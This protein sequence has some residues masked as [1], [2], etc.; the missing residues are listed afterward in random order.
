MNHS[1]RN[2]VFKR[3]LFQHPSLKRIIGYPFYPTMTEINSKL[4]MIREQILS[5]DAWSEFNTSLLFETSV[6]DL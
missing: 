6:I 4:T 1:S 5:L 2:N 3:Y